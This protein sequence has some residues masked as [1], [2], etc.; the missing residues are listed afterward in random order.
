ML[1]YGGLPAFCRRADREMRVKQKKSREKE[2]FCKGLPAM[3]DELIK[4]GQDESTANKG[5][6]EGPMAKEEPFIVRNLC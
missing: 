6:V 2:S 4:R 1:G 3:A 5:K